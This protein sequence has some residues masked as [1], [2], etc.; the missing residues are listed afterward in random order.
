MRKFV[1]IGKIVGVLCKTSPTTLK[2]LRSKCLSVKESFVKR[3]KIK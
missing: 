3:R 1:E 2:L